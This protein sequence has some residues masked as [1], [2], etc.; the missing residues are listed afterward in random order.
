MMVMKILN[1]LMTKWDHNC[2]DSIILL[3][4][5]WIP[6]TIFS[7]VFLVLFP[8]LIFVSVLFLAI[9]VTI[10]YF[11]KLGVDVLLRDNQAQPYKVSKVRSVSVPS[12]KYLTLWLYGAKF[13]LCEIYGEEK[14][15]LFITFDEIECTERW[16]MTKHVHNNVIFG[17][18]VKGC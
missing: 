8:E 16:I 14:T 11:N 5:L 3:S 2:I 1:K 7:V 10:V 15:K 12:L 18:T 6:I 4:N 9:C 13:Y 17:E